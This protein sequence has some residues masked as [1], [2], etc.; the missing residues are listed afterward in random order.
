MA[1]W[2]LGKMGHFRQLAKNR[3]YT[4]NAGFTGSLKKFVIV[5]YQP[6]A[7]KSLE[8]GCKMRRTELEFAR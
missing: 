5:N 3:S 8:G 6:A 2:D 7:P 4:N 1:L